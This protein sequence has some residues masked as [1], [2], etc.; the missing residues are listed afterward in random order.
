MNEWM[1][2][3]GREKKKNFISWTETEHDTHTHTIFVQHTTMATKRFI[4]T[5]NSPNLKN[6][7]EVGDNCYL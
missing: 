5:I 7:M 3:A 2:M 6:I 1:K 4:A